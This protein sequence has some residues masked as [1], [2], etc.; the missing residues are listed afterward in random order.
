MSSLPNTDEFSDISSLYGPGN[1]GSWYC[2][3]GSVTITWLYN[4]NQ[5]GKDTL[6]NDLIAAL[7][8]P[9]VASGHALHL[10]L[11]TP[12]YRWE[13]YGCSDESHQIRIWLACPH[14]FDT[15][16]INRYYRAVEAP[17]AVCNQFVQLGIILLFAAAGTRRPWSASWIFCVWLLTMWTKSVMLLKGGVQ[18]FFYYVLMSTA[19]ACSSHWL[20]FVGK[21]AWRMRRDGSSSRIIPAHRLDMSR[22]LDAGKIG[23]FLIYL[24]VNS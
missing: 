18:L 14:D 19:F 24:S 21:F 8:F 1:I 22:L 3:L 15:A 16:S 7:A 9:A 13:Q 12:R 5:H 4:H 6:T 20:H 2:L 10:I 11:S 17:L 23:G